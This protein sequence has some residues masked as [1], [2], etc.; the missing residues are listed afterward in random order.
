MRRLVGDDG[1]DGIISDI[2]KKID[3]LIFVVLI[4]A[5]LILAS[6]PTLLKLVIPFF[7]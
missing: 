6:N 2:R 5:I 7:K 1:E 3:R 4:L